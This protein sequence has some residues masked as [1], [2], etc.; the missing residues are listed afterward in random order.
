MYR[1]K[2][3]A[4]NG[5]TLIELLVVIAIIAI[6]IG[7]LLPAVQKVRDAANRM[8]CQNNLKQIGLACHNFNDTMGSLP[9]GVSRSGGSPRVYEYWS[10][11]AHILPYIEQDNVYREADT[12]MRTGDYYLTAQPNYF[13]WPWG[14]F[15]ANFATA[16]PNPALGRLIKT[17]QCPG[18][19]RTLRYETLDN[20]KV[21]F[22][23]YLGVSGVSHTSASSPLGRDMSGLI[24]WRTSYPK[25]GGGI[26]VTD[27]TDGLSN[28]A[29]AGERPPSQDLWYGWWFAGAGYDGS[30][31][32]DVLLGARELEY[33][34]SIGCSAN[35]KLGLQ[36]GRLTDNCD[37]S[38]F[39]S[40]HSGGSNFLMGDGSA[41]FVPYGADIILPQMFTKDGGEVYSIP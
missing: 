37:Q 36:P 23:A 39:W 41:R 22:T 28:T 15:W 27:A 3:V 29:L 6:L 34:Q 8:Y 24:V 13:W 32:G 17:Y 40:V 31:T 7:L 2:R 25:S 35:P 9:P 10:W 12:W 20:M 38:H 19:S 21:A 30:G 5:F 16:Q 4:R 14:D 26:K 18:D 11:L 33:A 1:A